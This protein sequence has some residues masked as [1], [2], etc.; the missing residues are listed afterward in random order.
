[1]LYV[2]VSLAQDSEWDAYVDV[3][4]RDSSKGQKPTEDCCKACGS[5]YRAA[6]GFLEWEEFC[7]WS[8]ADEGNASIAL[9][10]ESLQDPSS[11]GFFPEDVSDCVACGIGVITPVLLM[12]KSQYTKAFGKPPSSRDPK[13]PTLTLGT[14]LKEEK[15]WAFRDP[16]AQ[17]RKRS[18]TQTSLAPR[19][20]E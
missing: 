11:K 4:S 6:F 3:D 1:M 17:Y 14:G 5:L 18:C 10:E 7:T 2:V 20:K 8:T 16:E 9:A 19:T 13:I 12:D 15:F